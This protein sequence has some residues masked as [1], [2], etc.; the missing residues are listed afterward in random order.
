MKPT[1]LQIDIAK[2]VENQAKF[3]QSTNDINSP[4]H[5]GDIEV[6]LDDLALDHPEL[7]EEQLRELGDSIRDLYFVIKTIQ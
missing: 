1:K 7:T 4:T 5:Y 6:D 3:W 2:L